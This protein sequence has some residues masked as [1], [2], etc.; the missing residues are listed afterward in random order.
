MYY[1]KCVQLGPNN[2]EPGTYKD[3]KPDAIGNHV[4]LTIRQEAIGDEV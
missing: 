2:P 1:D 4:Q 3:R